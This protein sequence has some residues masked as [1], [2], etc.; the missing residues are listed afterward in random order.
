[1]DWNSPQRYLA[2]ESLYYKYILESIV[3]IHGNEHTRDLIT[4][5]FVGALTSAFS[6][7]I[8]ED[9]W[10][11]TVSTEGDVKWCRTLLVNLRSKVRISSSS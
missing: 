9:D 10:E 6:S 5:N 4:P 7:L 1:M 11:H 2:L 8:G 3:Q